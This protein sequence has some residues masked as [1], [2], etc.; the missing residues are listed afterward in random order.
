MFKYLLW[1]F[2]NEPELVKIVFKLSLPHELHVFLQAVLNHSFQHNAAEQLYFV[3]VP[4][5]V[6]PFGSS[7]QAVYKIVQQYY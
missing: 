6:T 4:G 7:S 5:E 2:K 1:L 3:P